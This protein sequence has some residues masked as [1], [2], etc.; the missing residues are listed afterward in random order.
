MAANFVPFGGNEEVREGLVRDTYGRLVVP[1]R[2]VTTFFPSSPI[3][4]EA[5]QLVVRSGSDMDT[6]IFFWP[7]PVPQ[8]SR[9]TL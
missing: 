4:S 8:Q 2:T 9:A 5:T 1:E 6:I 7:G 3:L